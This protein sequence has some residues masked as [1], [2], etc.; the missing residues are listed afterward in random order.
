MPPLEIGEYMTDRVLNTMREHNMLTINSVLVALSGGADSVALLHIMCKLS[1][2]Y[3]FKVYAAHVNHGL[4][5]DEAARDAD[6][7][8][9]LC[10]RLGIEY[11]VKKADVRALT[12]EWGV[13]EE[14]AGRKVRYD[15]FAELMEEH[16]ID[17]TATAHHK[18]DSAETIVMNFMRGSA[19][20]GLCGIPYRRDRFI[21]PLLDV[22]RS[23]IEKYC[24]ENSL[25][26][27]ID[28]TNL[29]TVYTRN[30]IRNILIPKIEKEFNPNFCDTVTANAKIIRDDEDFLKKTAEDEYRRIVN[31]NN[32]SVDEILSLH[33]AIARRVIR[34][35]MDSIC[36]TADIPSSAVDAVCKLCKTGRTGAACDIAKGVIARIEYGK[37][38]ISYAHTDCES[39]SYN[40]KVGESRFIPELGYTVE[41]CR[42]DE[43]C[44]DG[45]QYFMMPD[46]VDFVTVTNRRQGD[47]FVPSGMDGSK[48]VKEYMINEKIPKHMRSRTGILRI[49]D[50][51]AWIIGYRRDERFKFY[52][53][54]IKI[55]IIY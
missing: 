47:R 45:A 21:R 1:E 27:V 3:G 18:N 8:K 4:R 55:N 32:V 46:G 19:T 7:S 34:M 35:M 20:A 52:K 39:F 48:S 51:I 30:K 38:V 15:F 31:D 16:G 11:F 13:S 50:N 41:V 29:D 14:M 2:E 43:R 28:K 54:G 44:N 53:K 40:I 25:D 17:V 10:D 5:G 12:E 22:S 42:A 23:E 36:G 33:K 9:Q 37:L 6:F 49:G 26:Y 24:A